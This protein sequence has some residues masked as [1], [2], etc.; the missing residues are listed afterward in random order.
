MTPSSVN[1]PAR[2]GPSEDWA[3]SALDEARSRSASWA[4]SALSEL[5][6]E[7]EKSWN[8]VLFPSPR[9]EAW[10]YTNT[11]VIA[12]GSFLPSGTVSSEASAHVEQLLQASPDRSA[13]VVTFVDGAYARTLSSEGEID[14]V[15]FARISELS[16]GRNEDVA[17]H[18]GRSGAH[19]REA[20]AALATGLME[21]GLSITVDRGATVKRAIHIVNLSTKSGVVFAPRLSL[22]VGEGASVR[23][24]DSYIAS[25]AEKYLSLPVCEITADPGALVE[26]YRI[27]DEAV[28]SYH[29][30]FLWLEQGSGST[31]NS[32]ISSF[33]GAL[34]RNNVEVL[35]A[36]SNAHSTLNGVTILDGSQ[37]V[38]NA[39]LIHHMEPSA[40]SREHFKGVYA[41]R[42]RGVFSGTITVEPIAQ[43]TNAFQS[44]QALLLS[45]DAS[46]ESRPQL[47]IWADDVKCTHG[48][49]VGQLDQDALFYLRSR[50]IGQEDARNFLVHA[51]ASEVLA[52]IKSEP[53]R[54]HVEAILSR[55][56]DTLGR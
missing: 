17:K 27:Q 36:G 30:S 34:V 10:K 37:H 42:S 32:H 51:F 47:K 40:E 11:D 55:K 28:S 1:K 25:G 4:S 56:L 14:G 41:G 39:T 22:S 5:R 44:N 35:L 50:G 3:R 26:Y 12:K 33:G 6:S 46:I 54:D 2:P 49:T 31:V 15:T 29:V 53:V 18:F 48:A 24:I 52:S 21:E 19:S 23:V 38:D 8:K 43:K 7:G 16:D 45:S 20:F 13:F 9:L